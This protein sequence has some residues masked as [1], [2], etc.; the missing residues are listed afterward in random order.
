MSPS[1]HSYSKCS[2]WLRGNHLVQLPI[3]KTVNC[4]RFLLEVMVTRASGWFILFSIVCITL[5]ASTLPR[6][7]SF[8]SS[9]SPSPTNFHGKGMSD[10]AL[11]TSTWPGSGD[12][13]FLRCFA[14]LMAYAPSPM[15][16][17][18]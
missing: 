5:I 4:Y 3:N 13:H 10:K 6:R 9:S 17:I 2:F 11:R 12:Y 16:A 18:H 1:P 15:Q 7:C 14:I 8:G